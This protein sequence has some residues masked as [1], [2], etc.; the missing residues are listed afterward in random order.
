MVK[1]HRCPRDHPRA[2][3]LETTDQCLQ[4]YLGA[5]SK[6]IP[7]SEFQDLLEA[8][9]SIQLVRSTGDSYEN[10]KRLVKRW[11]LSRSQ[12]PLKEKSLMLAQ[13]NGKGKKNNELSSYKLNDQITYNLYISSNA[14][15]ESALAVALYLTGNIAEEKDEMLLDK[16]PA[17]LNLASATSSAV[18]GDYVLAPFASHFQLRCKAHQAMGPL[19][20]ERVMSGDPRLLN[21]GVLRRITR[22]YR[23]I[24][25]GPSCLFHTAFLLLENL[26]SIKKLLDGD[27]LDIAAETVD[28]NNSFSVYI[29]NQGLE[30]SKRFGTTIFDLLAS[31]SEDPIRLEH[32]IWNLVPEYHPLYGQALTTL[33]MGNTQDNNA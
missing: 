1:G 12:P 15:Y 22:V 6:C 24:T 23:V 16:L 29:P 21:L 2:V 13:E 8:S 30:M 32:C 33:L 17:V 14:F 7:N 27:Q 26:D 25:T 31:V 4:A 10:L 19:F 28:L 11:T 18:T 3:Y 9:I 20:V 5:A